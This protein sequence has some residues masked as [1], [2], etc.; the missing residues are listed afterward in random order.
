MKTPC[1]KKPLKLYVMLSI[2]HS[3]A[4]QEGQEKRVV[5]LGFIAG[6]T[7]MMVKIE[8]TGAEHAGS[9]ANLNRTIEK[10]IIIQS[11]LFTAM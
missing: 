4:P 2:Q 9:A 11:S 3:T 10:Q 8:I 1:T 7:A 5:S 6:C